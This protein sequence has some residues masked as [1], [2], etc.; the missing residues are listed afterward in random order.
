MPHGDGHGHEGQGMHHD[1]HA[2]REHHAMPHMDHGGHEHHGM[3]HG[4]R[5]KHGGMD[6]GG[7]DMSMVTPVRP[8]ATWLAVAVGIVLIGMLLLRPAWPLVDALPDPDSARRVGHLLMEK[9]MVAF[10]GAGFLILVGIFGAVLLARPS[11]HPDDPSRSARV[12]VDAKPEPIA[13]DRLVPLA[14]PRADHEHH[15]HGEHGA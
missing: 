4:G 12:A 8:I 10:E 14:G 5:D 9:Y 15:H 3:H 2:G 11:T 13:D 7:M 6:M 1:E